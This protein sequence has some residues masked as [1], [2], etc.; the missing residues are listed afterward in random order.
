MFFFRSFSMAVMPTMN[1]RYVPS[2]TSI[3]ATKNMARAATGSSMVR[4]R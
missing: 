2:I 4:A 1:S 3:T